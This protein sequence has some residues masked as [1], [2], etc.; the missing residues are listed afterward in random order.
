MLQNKNGKNYK[1]REY[2]LYLGNPS[3]ESKMIYSDCDNSSLYPK[4][5]LDDLWKNFEKDISRSKECRYF[6]YEQNG[7]IL[8]GKVD[9]T[10]KGVLHFKAWDERLSWY[11]DKETI[12]IENVFLS[13]EDA[14]LA[15][16][17]HAKKEMFC[18][19]ERT[20]EL[21][22]KH[23]NVKNS[24]FEIR[25]D[26]LHRTP[27][28]NDNFSISALNQIHDLFQATYE[29]ELIVLSESYLKLRRITNPVQKTNNFYDF[30]IWFYQ[31]Y[32]E[33]LI[34]TLEL[35]TEKEFLEWRHLYTIQGSPLKIF[36]FVTF[37]P[38]YN[39]QMSIELNDSVYLNNSDFYEGSIR[40]HIKDKEL[41]VSVQYLDGDTLTDFDVTEE[42]IESG[43]S[44]LKLSFPEKLL[45]HI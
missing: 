5:V 31:T 32:K 10:D 41:M 38:K 27:F 1:L 6:Y 8:K 30:L 18:L 12:K 43:P 34:K 16:K 11:F 35:K 25:G 7:E 9:Y 20:K 15:F 29:K 21:F 3:R 33:D 37:S 36:D 40:F 26:N 23:Q 13:R 39:N 24:Y 28:K 22:H 42:M 45:K 2:L 19:M 14:E 17:I 44:L 4:S